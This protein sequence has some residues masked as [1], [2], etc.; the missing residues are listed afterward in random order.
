MGPLMQ[1][2]DGIWKKLWK[3]LAPNR[4]RSFAWLVLYGHIVCNY[5]K[6][7]RGFNDD[8]MCQLCPNLMETLDHIF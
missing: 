1:K 8:G 3:V 7:R 6:K 5:E 4:M 2:V